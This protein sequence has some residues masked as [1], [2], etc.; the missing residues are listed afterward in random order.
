MPHGAQRVRRERRGQANELAASTYVRSESH[1][2]DRFPLSAQ[3]K[4][5]W[6]AQRVLG[7]ENTRHVVS[8]MI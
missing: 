4:V 6:P 8:Q 1:E 5:P 7:T 3:L 2:G